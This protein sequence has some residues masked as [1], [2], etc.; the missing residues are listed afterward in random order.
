M[1]HTCTY[2]LSSYAV[3][4]HEEP[5]AILIEGNG[6]FEIHVAKRYGVTS[7]AS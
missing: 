6:E 3:D 7:A 4:A 1:G 5:D 2:S